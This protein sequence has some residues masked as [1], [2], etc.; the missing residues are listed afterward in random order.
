MTTAVTTV[1]A[2]CHRFLLGRPSFAHPSQPAQSASS[3][4]ELDPGS[5]GA[6]LAASALRV[7]HRAQNTREASRHAPQWG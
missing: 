3:H 2:S 6:G 4:W 5:R 1:L 7:S